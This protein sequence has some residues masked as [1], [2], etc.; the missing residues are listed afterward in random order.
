VVINAGLRFEEELIDRYGQRNGSTVHLERL[1][2]TDDAAL[3]AR[4]TAEESERFRELERDLE[5]VLN[6]MGV[7]NIVVRIRRFEP[8]ELPAVIVMDPES[9]AQTQLKNLV[10]QPWFAESFESITKEALQ[11]IQRRPFYLSLNVNNPLIQRLADSD[12]EEDAVREVM[13]GLFNTA[14]LY[15]HNLLT[16]HNSDVL[17]RQFLHLC[18]TTLTLFTQAS[19]V[20][21]ELE[22]KRR[23]ELETTKRK[24]ATTARRPEHTRVFMITPFASEYKALE[25]A[26]RHVFERPPFCFEVK[27]ARDSTH[28]PNLMEDLRLHMRSAHGFLADLSELNPNVMLELGAVMLAEDDRPYLCLRGTDAVKLPADLE[29]IKYVSYGSLADG[30][31]SLAGQLRAE[32]LRE[33]KLIHEGIQALLSRRTK[34]FL[35]RLM[36]QHDVSVKLQPKQMDDLMGGYATVEDLLAADPGECARLARI[37]Q[38]QVQAIQDDLRGDEP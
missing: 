12:R 5:F 18:E 3:F 17:H 37:R 9:Q 31:E 26:I 34:R 15:S 29:G 22:E 14:V 16:Q 30:T 1:D 25:E 6:R 21:R 20:Q 24:E 4:P 33:G 27:L 23:Q 35:S 8:P 2:A 7:G 11:Q 36:L 10:N 19:S 28:A 32:L 13:L 38:A